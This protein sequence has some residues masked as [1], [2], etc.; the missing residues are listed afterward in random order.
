MSLV[1]GEAPLADHSSAITSAWY[2]RTRDRQPFEEE[3]STI[4]RT[5]E[6]ADRNEAVQNPNMV[7]REKGLLQQRL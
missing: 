4:G 6:V 5:F 7:I 1:V 2:D 3:L